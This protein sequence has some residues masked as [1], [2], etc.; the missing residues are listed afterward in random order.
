MN[1]EQVPPLPCW[2]FQGAGVFLTGERDGGDGSSVSYGTCLVIAAKDESKFYGKLTRK[3]N[4]FITQVD[5]KAVINEKPRKN[6]GTNFQAGSE[7]ERKRNKEGSKSVV[8][9][10]S[11]TRVKN[12]HTHIAR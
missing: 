6:G 2:A 3:F 8:G 9:T 12:E 7:A 10:E 1:D 5:W 11:G 4:E